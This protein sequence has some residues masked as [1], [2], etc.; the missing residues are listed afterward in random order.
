MLQAVTLKRRRISYIQAVRF[1]AFPVKINPLLS[2]SSITIEYF[3]LNARLHKTPF[4]AV[5]FAILKNCILP[6]AQHTCGA[7]N[8]QRNAHRFS[9]RCRGNQH[10]YVLPI[11]GEP[12]AHCFSLEIGIWHNSNFIFRTGQMLKT[13]HATINYRVDTS[14]MLYRAH[15]TRAFALHLCS[16]DQIK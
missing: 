1:T 7:T 11:M 5:S 10:N 9:V 4:H 16:K 13:R 8:E 12:S 15:C 14:T 3:S 6:R 2:Y